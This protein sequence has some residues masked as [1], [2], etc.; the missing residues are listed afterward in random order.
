MYLSPRNTPTPLLSLVF[1]KH[2]AIKQPDYEKKKKVLIV[3][4][5]FTVLF[6]T[7]IV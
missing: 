3:W 6:L 4:N 2:T 5:G 7:Y 1:S